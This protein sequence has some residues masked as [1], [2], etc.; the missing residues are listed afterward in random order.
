MYS[1]EQLKMF[2]IGVAL[3]MAHYGNVDKL[4]EI[5]DEILEY[6]REEDQQA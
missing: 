4:L 3:Y 6:I 1:E 5:S 2:A